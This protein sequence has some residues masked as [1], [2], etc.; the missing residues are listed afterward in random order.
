MT[1]EPID[2]ALERSHFSADWHYQLNCPICGFEC[3]HQ[4]GAV[5]AFTRPAGED[6]ETVVQLTGTATRLPVEESHN[7]S[8][9]RDAVRISFTCENG[10]TFTMDLLQHKG[11]TFI[12]FHGEEGDGEG[13]I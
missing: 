1:S 12:S 7:P 5:T 10:C 8:P 6:G 3:T 2:K 11:T 13:P 4:V 9:R